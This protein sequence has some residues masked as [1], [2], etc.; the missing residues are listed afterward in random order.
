MFFFLREKKKKIPSVKILIN[1]CKSVRENPNPCVKIRK[2][3]ARET[4]NTVRE[5]FSQITS[6]KIYVKISKNIYI[7]PVK[8][9]NPC[10]KKSLKVPVKNSDCT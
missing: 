5:I 10:V 3:T 1:L 4:N 8:T 6:V 9:Q 2:K 7:L